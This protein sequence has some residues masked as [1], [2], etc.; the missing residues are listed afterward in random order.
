MS[1]PR[2]YYEILGVQRSADAD[3][4]KKA[5]RKLAIQF[6]PDKNP[7]NPEAEE[8]FKEAAAAYEVLSNADKR[9]KYDRFG[10]A[11][12]QGGG[13]GGFHDVDDIFSQFGDIFGDIF[14]MGGGGS[15]RRRGSR[16]SPRKGADLRYLTE[17]SLKDVFT[18]LEREI[19][20]AAEE[21][22]GECKGSG[23][24]KGSEAVTCNTCGGAGQVVRS[25]GFFSMASTCPTCRGEGVQIKNPCRSCHGQGR[26]ERR[27]KLRISIPAGVDTGTRLRISNEGE[28]GY[29][30][31][32]AGD[33]YVEIRIKS[34]GNYERRGED[35]LT[36]LEVPYVQMLLG[37][38]IQFQGPIGSLEV[39]VP[40]GTKA[41]Q[42]IKLPGAGLPSLRGS[43]K[44]DLYLLLQVGFPAKLRKEEE[45]L[46]AEIAKLQGVEI[47]GESGFSIFGKK[48]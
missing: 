42:T 6:H 3:E 43:R 4:I 40:K 27:R 8:K 29:N 5:Y 28:G 41:G 46:L 37:G 45:K 36:E 18:G 22:C 30:G 44:G 47:K 16:T 25:Q 48:K 17:I 12:F 31:G 9:A 24:A 39:E 15:S 21:S 32:P 35:L 13:G 38:K 33:L 34:E 11:A 1:Q 20:F 2:D 23:A 10:H 7:D 26:A 14:G 19:E